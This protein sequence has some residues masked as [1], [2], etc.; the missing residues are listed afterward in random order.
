MD[1]N[2]D[3]ELTERTASF[4]TPSSL[5]C[6][7]LWRKCP[8]SRTHG[9]H[10]H[11]FEIKYESYKLTKPQVNPFDVWEQINNCCTDFL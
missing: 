7:E 8:L 4:V 6:H 10:V 11:G 9:G 5:D 1:F 2:K 3:L